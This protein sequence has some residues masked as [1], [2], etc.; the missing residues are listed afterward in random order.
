MTVPDRRRWSK[1]FWQAAQRKN[2][3]LILVTMRLRWHRC[4]DSSEPQQSR[5]SVA[6]RHRRR[7][8]MRYTASSPSPSPLL[9]SII[10]G[11]IDAADGYGTKNQRRCRCSASGDQR[12][13]QNTRKVRDN[14]GSENRILYRRR[15]IGHLLCQVLAEIIFVDREEKP[16]CHET[17]L[18][19]IQD[20]SLRRCVIRD[21]IALQY[22]VNRIT[23]FITN[24]IIL[25]CG[26]WGIIR[27]VLLYEI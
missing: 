19:Y 2:G 8:M 14:P 9:S 1:P 17:I 11:N 26:L 7:G 12:W 24:N 15:K 25:N 5:A 23:I 22:I 21:D 18:S 6:I 4:D 16:K 10:F 27:N 13:R 20:G 3:R